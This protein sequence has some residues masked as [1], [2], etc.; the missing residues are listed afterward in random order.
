MI[1]LVVLARPRWRD[2][3]IWRGCEVT[4]FFGVWMYIASFSGK[5]L[6][7]NAYHVTILLHLLGTAYI[8]FVVVRDI[9]W[10]EHDPVR[11]DGSDGPSG[12]VL[13]RTPDVVVLAPGRR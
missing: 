5:G 12:G 3:L 11:A 9:L 8:C 2:F 4:Y 6:S 13:D 10:P 1:P 7:Q